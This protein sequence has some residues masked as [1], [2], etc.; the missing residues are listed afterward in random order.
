MSK[1]HIIFIPGKNPKPP[2]EQ[3]HALLLRALLT[4][5]RRIDP[6][7]ADELEQERAFSLIAW[8]F[9]YYHNHADVEAELPWIETTLQKR[10]ANRRDRREARHWHNKINWLLYS[11]ADLIPFIVRWLP[12]PACATICETQRYFENT[13][14]IAHKIRA[15]I[16]AQLRALLAKGYPVLLIGHSMGSVIAFDTLWELTHQEKLKGKLDFLSIGSPLGMKFVQHRMLG[17][18]LEGK[19]A[20]PDTI[21]HWINIAAHGD[22][23]ALDKD[24]HNDYQIM[25]KLGLLESI[26][27][28]HNKVYNWYRNDTGLNAHRSYGYLVNDVVAKT[29]AD[30]WR[31]NA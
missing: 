18:Y 26:T 22:I 16:K 21:R 30:W 25:L 11:I 15:P 24:I 14:N 6:Q 23:T 17:H 29:I 28:R 1:R 9:A 5:L 7:S 13:H 3:H 4:G 2:P 31:A 19:A 27:D 10:R 20:Y 12:G 8:N